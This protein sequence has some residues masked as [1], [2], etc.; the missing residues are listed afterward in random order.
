MDLKTVADQYYL[1][2]VY[3]T[4][5]PEGFIDY[6]LTTRTDDQIM[7][8]QRLK[9]HGYIESAGSGYH[10]LTRRGV[11]AA[12]EAQELREQAAERAEK[13]CNEDSANATKQSHARK[14]QF[15]HDFKVA[16]FT[17]AL[18]LALERMCENFDL[19]FEYLKALLH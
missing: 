3:L 2:L 6:N 18:T 4:L 10:R 13:Q 16:A 15:R 1:I 17:V 9:D 7:R 19:I 8:F 12:K 11:S 5:T 14:Q